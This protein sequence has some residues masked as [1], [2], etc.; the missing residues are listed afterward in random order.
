MKPSNQ[1]NQFK[2]SGP[3]KFGTRK[4][5]FPK[6]PALELQTTTLWDYP[7]QHYGTEMQGD[8]N[9]IGATP[10]YVIWNLLERYT[11]PGQLVVD[12]MCGSGTTID[13][14]KDMDRV[15][16]GFDLAPSRPDIEQNDARTLPLSSNTVDFVFIDPPYSTHVKYSGREECI[17]ELSAQETG[18]Y[19]AMAQVISEIHRVLKPGGHCGLYVSDSF[20]KGKPFCPIGFELFSELRKHM[21]PVDIISVTRHNKK[22]KKGNW[23]E[24]ASEGNFFLRGFNYLFIMKKADPPPSKPEKKLKG[25]AKKRFFERKEFL[26][27]KSKTRPSKNLS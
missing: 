23:H 7:S 12:P 2:K 19:E 15:V 13:V 17:G 4:K 21:E 25:R 14:C 5:F 20:Q 3:S 16:R 1:S 27:T 9:Y 6:K 10:S 24:A 11:K 18:Y 26:K 22:L 8:K